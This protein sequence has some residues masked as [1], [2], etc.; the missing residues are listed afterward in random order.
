MPG[1]PSSYGNAFDPF[2]FNLAMFLIDMKILVIMYI[3]INL[4][5]FPSREQKL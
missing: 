3:Y 5:R 2:S 1:S 4:T